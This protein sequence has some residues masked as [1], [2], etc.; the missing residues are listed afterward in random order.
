MQELCA[1]LLAHHHHHPGRNRR[2][3]KRNALF[4]WFVEDPTRHRT[5][6]G[7]PLPP[8]A[9]LARLLGWVEK[10]YLGGW[11]RAL[12]M[13][14]QSKVRQGNTAVVRTKYLDDR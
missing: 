1:P 11:G 7:C 9:P 4:A 14:S 2:F 5:M 8:V 13:G 6:R 12:R 3:R 10:P